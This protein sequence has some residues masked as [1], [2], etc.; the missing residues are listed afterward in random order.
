MKTLTIFVPSSK[1]KV[2][3]YFLIM[4]RTGAPSIE[5]SIKAKE[6]LSLEGAVRTIPRIAKGTKD[7]MFDSNVNHYF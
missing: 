7:M 3:Y 5:F 2:K 6:N 1:W 4:A